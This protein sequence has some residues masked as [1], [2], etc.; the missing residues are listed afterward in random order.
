MRLC[1]PVAR[2]EMPYEFAKGYY[3]RV[4]EGV[5]FGRVTRLFVAPLVRAAIRV[6]GHHPMLDYVSAFR[7]PLAGECAFSNNLARELPVVAGW[8]LEIGWLCEVHRRLP[9]ERVCQVELG[10]NYDHKHRPLRSARGRAGLVEMA[11]EIARIF[12]A[13]LRAEGVVIDAAALHALEVAY[14]KT[15]AEAVA[16]HAHD[17]L[18]N[19]LRHDEKNER[20]TAGAF[21]EVLAAINDE[22]PD[23][24]LP[25]WSRVFEKI[26]AIS[27]HLRDLVV[28]D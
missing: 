14:R 2:P 11:A 1:A 19:G 13:E 16:R 23:S 21:S 22:K 27:G 5:M 25:A 4:T 12:V 10:A 28:A 15:A 20:A 26:P 24:V 8:G 18:L 17:A 9:P 7:Y 6:L 3:R